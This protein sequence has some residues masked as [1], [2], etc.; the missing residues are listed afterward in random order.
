M[1]NV[2]IIIQNLTG[3]GAERAAANLSVILAEYCNIHLIV[4]DAAKISYPYKGT[5]HDLQLPPMTNRLGKVVNVF[6]RVSAVR[7]I[8]V[9]EKI[10][11]AIS[12]M[13]G[14][15]L[16][17]VLA[18]KHN[19]ALTSVRIQMSESRSKGSSLALW[20][21]KKQ[22]Q[23]I[24]MRS[25]RVIAVSKGVEED[26]NQQYGI[27]AEKL[28]TIYNFCNYQALYKAA[29]ANQMVLE[30]GHA[31][32]TMGRMTE[33]KGQWH[34]I[35]AMRA[36]IEK[37][38]DAK[39]YIFGDGPYRQML[40]DIS[41]KLDL[42]EHIRFLG[43]VQAPHACYRYCDCFVLPSLY[44][45]LANVLLEAMAW[46]LPCIASDCYSGSREIIEPKT[47]IKE[48]LEAIEY[49]EYGILVSVCGKENK[50]STDPLTAEEMQLADAI[51]TLLTDEAMRKNYTEKS[52]KRVKDFSPETIAQ[53]WLAEINA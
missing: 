49:G 45:G 33:Q 6:R 43:Y 25:D 50:N 22:M 42:T 38:P 15:N 32:A 47:T 16:V 17:N 35:R 30:S 18:K 20:L 46:G 24:S 31:I 36:V 28:K 9:Q 3:G 14:A 19:K 34:L 48:R 26:L 37:V 2:A 8:L 27:P 7:K 4:F 10:D 13:D 53:V 5:L 1:K 12:L 21:A 40:E 23:F 39:L 52:L 51:T 29:E 44:E 41:E 11:C